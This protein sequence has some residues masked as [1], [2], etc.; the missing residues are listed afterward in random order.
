MDKAFD[1]CFGGDVGAVSGEVLGEDAAG[2]S[3]DTAAL[4]NVLC[5]LRE[6]EEGSAQ[7]SGDDFV[8]GFD[9]AFS[10]RREGHDACV[11]DDDV[12]LAEGL[13]GLFEE[14]LD[15]F[16]VCDISLDC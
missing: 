7:V 3:D 12:D 2:E 11:V 14:L 9:V 13:E 1:A 6:D 16:R 15:V 4:C 8:E 10:D 5:R